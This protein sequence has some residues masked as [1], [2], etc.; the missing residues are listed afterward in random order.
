MNRSTLVLNATYEPLGVVPVKRGVTLILE[1][2]VDVLEEHDEPFRSKEVEFKQPSVVRLRYY[3][4]IPYSAKV[5]LNRSLLFARD[6]YTCQFTHCNRRAENI[7][8][9]HPRSKGGK[10]VWEN[11]VA[12]CERCNSK[13]AN[14]T[15]TE[16]GWSLKREPVVP[17]KTLWYTRMEAAHPEWKKYL[18]GFG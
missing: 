8:H 1:D 16:L 3:V 11:V 13:K 4:K 15:L 14:K 5:P 17:S 12:S 9:V 6:N 10:N 7:D 18:E 2:K